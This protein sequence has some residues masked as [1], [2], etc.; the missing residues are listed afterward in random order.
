MSTKKIYL[1]TN[2]NG[3]P[4]GVCLRLSV[5]IELTKIIGGSY[6]LVTLFLPDGE[7][8]RITNTIEGY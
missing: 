1:I 2:T 8:F 7:E 3:D 4:V 6:S 5:A